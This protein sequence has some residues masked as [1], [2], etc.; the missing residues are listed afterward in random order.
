MRLTAHQR[1]ALERAGFG[2]EDDEIDSTF[3][4]ILDHPTPADAYD[5][6]WPEGSRGPVRREDVPSI[7]LPFVAFRVRQVGL[8]GVSPQDEIVVRHE[9]EVFALTTEPDDDGVH[10]IPQLDEHGRE[11]LALLKAIVAEQSTAI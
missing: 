10:H 2:I 9:W 1:I 8:V 4:A 6:A 11:A 5:W 7:Q 3:V